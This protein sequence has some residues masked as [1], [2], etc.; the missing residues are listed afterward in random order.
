M[1]ADPKA[2]LKIGV[3]MGGPSPEHA[4]SLKS[5]RGVAE[6]LAARGWAVQ[7]ILL[8]N[9]VSVDEAQAACR[10]ILLR[11]V[12]DVAFI[13]LHGPFGEDGTVQRLLDDLQIR[14]TGSDAASSALGMDKLA[15]RQRFAAAGL[16]VPRWRLIERG[17]LSTEE[18]ELAI[19]GFQMPV[20]VKPTNQGSSIGVSIV[21]ESAQLAPA[22][23]EAFRYDAHVLVEAF[24][25][26]RELTV[27]IVGDEVL[28][29]IEVRPKHAFFDYAAKYTPGQTE[30]LVPA[31]ISPALAAQA[32]HA[33]RRAHQALG[34]RHFSRVD[35][36]AA[37]DGVPVVLEVNTIPGMTAMS[38]L[39]KA[40]A[41][42]RQSYD[43]LCEQIVLMACADA[44]RRSPAGVASHRGA[45]RPAG[46]RR[47]SAHSL[48]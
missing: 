46:F 22:L 6:A 33:A 26:G 34:C 35:L 28:P 2:S 31:P 25:R 14:Y 8:P 3:L 42:R 36:I 40:A 23:E 43:E 13:A 16:A 47:P 32:Q 41:C 5:G 48:R 4:I 1:R 7:P 29:V 30:Y 12:I 45:R 24:V 15:S 21:T 19:R 18:V 37:D 10:S 9:D 17:R 27:G 39:P 11:D 38:L 20:V 44:R